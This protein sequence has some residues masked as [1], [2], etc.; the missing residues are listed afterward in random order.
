MRIGLIADI[1]GNSVALE[2][3]LAK[4]E[5]DTVD[6][7][8]CLG[9]VAALGPQPA[10]VLARLH[11]V[12]CPSVLG[13]TDAWLLNG[14]PADLT[15]PAGIA[16]SEITRWGADLLSDQDRE[17]LRTCPQVMEKGMGDGR[18][19]L[20]FHASPRSFDE[21]IS[22]TTPDD[23]LSS[24]LSNHRASVFAGGHT[25]V[26][27]LRRYED[28]HLINPGSVGLPGVGPGTPDLPINSRVSWAEYAVLE[29][30]D[31]R[32]S[33]TLSRV[34][35]DVERTLEAAQ[36]SGMPH[37]DWWIDKWGDVHGSGPDS[38]KAR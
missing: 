11:E 7:L 18:E 38:I 33:V 8:V 29:V 21:A 32:F 26:Q 37:L 28:A 24:M 15:S 12:E 10:E 1:H 9:D 13:N 3:V 31:G 16:M 6:C 17:Y 35:V 34:P 25:H 30:G 20:C 36:A 4:L 5:R 22:A 23:E 2:T 27:L 14:P 19:L